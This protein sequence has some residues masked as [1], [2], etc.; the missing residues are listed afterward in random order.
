MLENSAGRFYVGHTEDLAQRI[1]FHN[2]GQSHYTA[3]KGPWNLVYHE[4]YATRGEAMKRGSEI[5]R[6]KSAVRIR[7]LIASSEG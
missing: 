6:W 1:H 7:A 4:V 2:S 5:K 3:R